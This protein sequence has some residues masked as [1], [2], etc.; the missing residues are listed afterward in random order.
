MHKDLP[1]PSQFS[2]M[3]KAACLLL[4]HPD[5]SSFAVCSRRN[6]TVYGLPGGKMDPGETM[7]QT[8]VRET[9]EEI[10]VLVDVSKIE[11]LFADAIPGDKDFWVETFIAVSPT[12]EL[13]EMESGI[14]V[15]WI[16]W[17]SFLQNNAFEK[18]NQGVHEAFQEWVTKQDYGDT[19]PQV[20]P[21]NF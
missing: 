12:S 6:S 3:A 7:A 19:A 4:L 20:S 10:G 1:V 2:H 17:P 9:A 16:T 21:T 11:L 15:K 8:A 5:G 13:K 14:T 18:Y